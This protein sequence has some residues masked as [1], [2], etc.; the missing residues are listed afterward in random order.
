VRNTRLKGD[1]SVERA[2]ARLDR[3]GH[4]ELAAQVR[5][6]T[7]SASAAAPSGRPSATVMNTRPAWPRGGSFG[8]AARATGILA[9]HERCRDRGQSGRERSSMRPPSEFTTSC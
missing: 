1:G 5:A 4:A 6:G 3:D 8:G 2:L 9:Q 7:L